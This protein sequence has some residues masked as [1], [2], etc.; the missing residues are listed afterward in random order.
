MIL[1]VGHDRWQQE[2]GAVG[3]CLEK[4]SETTKKGSTRAAAATAVSCRESEVD[5]EKR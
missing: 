5:I 4:W 1:V 3:T 2:V